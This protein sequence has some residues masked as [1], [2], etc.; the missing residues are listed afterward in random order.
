MLQRFLRKGL[1]TTFSEGNILSMGLQR[2]CEIDSG[3]TSRL[4]LH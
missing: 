2:L 3:S 4:E 1:L